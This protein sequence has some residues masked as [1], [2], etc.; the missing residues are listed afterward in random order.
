MVVRTQGN[1]R[2]VTGLRVGAANV[3]RY[4]SRS[5]D[6]VELRMGDL[7]IQCKLS[8]GF[9]DGEPEIHDP[10]LCQWLKYK[11]SQE[12]SNRKPIALA[13]VQSGANSFTLW[14][15]SLNRRESRLESAA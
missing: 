3:R 9:W 1:G 12:R 4:F 13:M 7:R 5:M 15:L 11:V 6:D 8:P 10:R 2:E 14:P